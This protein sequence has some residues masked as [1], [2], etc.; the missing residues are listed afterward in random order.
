MV[1]YTIIWSAFFIWKIIDN[2]DINTYFSKGWKFT[3]RAVG[4]ILF[5]T[6]II[7]LFNWFSDVRLYTSVYSISWCL[8]LITT[9]LIK[10]SST[11]T[12]YWGNPE[13][14]VYTPFKNGTVLI[15]SSDLPTYTKS[16]MLGWQKALAALKA[17][18]LNPCYS[19]PYNDLP[20]ENYGSSA[21]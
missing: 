8:W 7:S 18:G 21:V 13:L 4:L 17:L 20:K 11:I 6:C 19:K 10:L 1:Y 15:G 2:L 5:I 16:H 14:L 9:L 3:Y 12:K